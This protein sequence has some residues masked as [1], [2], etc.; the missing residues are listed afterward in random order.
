MFMYSYVLVC[1]TADTRH[2]SFGD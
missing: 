2:F 1:I